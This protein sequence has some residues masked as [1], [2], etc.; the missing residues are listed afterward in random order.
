VSIAPPPTKEKKSFWGEPQAI[1]TI[2]AAVIAAI[3]AI[4]VALISGDVINV[5]AGPAIQTSSATTAPP[6]S[7]SPPPASETTTTPPDTPTPAVRRT[8]KLVLS[9]GHPANLD[10][11]EPAWD[12]LS[13]LEDD[14]DIA[15]NG[16]YKGAT[17]K[18]AGKSNIASVTG[19]PDYN[20][21]LEETGYTEEIESA[22]P[23]TTACVRTGEE[24]FAFVTVQKL[25][26]DE[27]GGV[28]KIQLAVVVWQ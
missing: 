1:A 17:L 16:Y 3:A 28:E 7:T 24:R 21:C 15:V 10:S 27:G 5:S 20:T 25:F 18:A 6:P 13:P 23:G 12:V 4:V 9:D 8:G 11:M 2:V 22:K 26:W 14:F 19:S